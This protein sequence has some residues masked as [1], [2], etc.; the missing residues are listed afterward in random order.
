ML[1]ADLSIFSV[2]LFLHFLALFITLFALLIEFFGALIP[3]NDNL[4]SLANPL[5]VLD[6]SLLNLVV[7]H[8]TVE[9]LFG[10]TFLYLQV[11]NLI[12]NFF[13]PCSD[14]DQVI[15]LEFLG[16]VEDRLFFFDLSDLFY[17][18]VYDFICRRHR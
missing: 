8:C 11:L 14:V 2:A 3:L 10:F 5:N 1:G 18:R 7:A 6:E 9:S 15:L 16:L 13:N 17:Q 4:L 12:E